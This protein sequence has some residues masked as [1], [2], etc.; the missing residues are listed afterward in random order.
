MI[1][2]NRLRYQPALNAKSIAPLKE[3]WECT[4]VFH[5]PGFAPWTDDY[6]GF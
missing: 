1:R 5:P 2:R 4:E 6:H 3:K